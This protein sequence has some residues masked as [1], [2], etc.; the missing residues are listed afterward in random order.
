M[1]GERPWKCVRERYPHK[2]ELLMEMLWEP[3]DSY[4]ARVVKKVLPRA[5]VLADAIRSYGIDVSGTLIEWLRVDDQRC[6]VE[7]IQAVENDLKD[8]ILRQ[9]AVQI[10]RVCVHAAVLEGRYRTALATAAVL[11]AKRCVCLLKIYGEKQSISTI[12]TLHSER[13][14]VSNAQPQLAGVEVEKAVHDSEPSAPI[15]T[16]SETFHRFTYGCQTFLLNDT[17]AVRAEMLWNA[18][19][20]EGNRVRREAL[21]DGTGYDKPSKLFQSKDGRRFYSLF[22][23]NDGRAYWIENHT[24]DSSPNA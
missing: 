10:Q 7:F 22:V 23:R 4:S 11:A 13:A 21:L 2:A 18:R 19:S 1:P 15:L 9:I 24:K 14:S 3:L 12:S 6:D 5:D 16:P 17:E 8:A 20:R